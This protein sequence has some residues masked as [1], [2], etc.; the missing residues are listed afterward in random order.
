[1]FYLR[2][3]YLFAHSVVQH[4]LC[5]DFCVVCLR[6]MSPMLQFSLDF[7]SW[8]PFGFLWHLSKF[9]IWHHPHITFWL[10]R[11]WRY[12]RGNQNPLIEERQT[13]Q[14]QK[15]TVQK[16][17]QRSTKHTHKTKDRVTRTPL[18]T[19]GE[20]RCSRSVSCHMYNISSIRE[21][22]WP[23]LSFWILESTEGHWV[24]VLFLTRSWY[25]R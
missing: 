22:R 24:T 17:K 18:K 11:A 13:T 23:W 10:R 14:W 4:I 16:D 6:L 19:R 20:L 7:N 21:S 25:L 9:I 15:E 2:Y 1:M 12:Q 3:L 5:C 8:L